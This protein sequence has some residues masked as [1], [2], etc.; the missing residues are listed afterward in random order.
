MTKRIIYTIFA[1]I[2]LV[3]QSVAGQKTGIDLQNQLIGWVGCNFSDP[4]RY[5]TGVRYIPTLSPWWKPGKNSKLDAEFSVNTYGNLLFKGSGFDTANYDF[6][7]YRMWF[8]YSTS[9]FEL[10]A[11]LQKINF[12]SANILRPLMWFDK[13]DYRD[14]LQLTDGVYGL[15]GRYYFNNNTNIWLWTLYGNDKV[16]GW[17]SAPS[18][19]DI[20]EY[21]GRV[22]VPVPKGEI[23]ISYHHR[24]TDYSEIYSGL[25]LINETLFNEN[26]MA[27]DGKWDL[28]VGLWFE[29]SKNL[30]DK[31]NQLVS[32]WETYY[33]IG[34]DYTFSLGNGL[35]LITEFFHYGNNPAQRQEKINRNYSILALS[36][37]LSLSHNM[38]G[39][40]YYNWETKEWNRYF[41][42]QLKY[43][44]LSL[45]FMAFWNPDVQTLYSGPDD[46][47]I[48]AGKGI[49]IML[50]LDI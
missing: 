33:N 29:Y 30:N 38:S 42:L 41:S 44:Y 8:R 19:K 22:Q 31:D 45:Y 39:F 13:M 7:P 20:P 37:P 48:F 23:A 16:K 5:Q 27:V 32:R 12:G 2:F 17:E 35:N 25:P 28:G 21:G 18:V 50:V 36:Y 6:K 46:N 24:R 11:G 10:R 4:L 47:N 49:Q 15:L 26:R 1:I 34:L 3:W 40:V 43:D 14:P 9:N